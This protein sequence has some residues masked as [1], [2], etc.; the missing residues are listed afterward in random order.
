[1]FSEAESLAEKEQEQEKEPVK[2]F[3][4]NV[5]DNFDAETG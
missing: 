3:K 1:M 5:F 2:T 4:P